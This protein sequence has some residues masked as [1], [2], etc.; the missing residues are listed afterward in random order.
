MQRQQDLMYNMRPEELQAHRDMQ[1]CVANM[2]I[3]SA[4]TNTRSIA[5]AEPQYHK[6]AMQQYQQQQ[7]FPCPTPPWVHGQSRPLSPTG[8]ASPIQQQQEQGQE[9]VQFFDIGEHI[10]EQFPEHPQ[11]PGSG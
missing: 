1:I 9:P 7:Q 11:A 2:P 5:V 3:R 10:Q 8:P 6:Q 4:I